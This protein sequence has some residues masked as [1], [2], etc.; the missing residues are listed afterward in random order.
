VELLPYAIQTVADYES[1]PDLVHKRMRW[2]VVMRH[3]RPWG[4]FGLLLTQALPWS[5]AAIAVRPSLG[6]AL[7]YLGSYLG[8]R[9]AMSWV[10]GIHGLKQPVL[11]KKL[12]LIPVW[13]AMAFCIWLISF[14]RNTVRWRGGQYYIRDG[15][16]V[17]ATANPAKE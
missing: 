6:T 12:W 8:L 3:M 5:L 4:H 16:L 11:W 13:D 1:M 15:M 9:I 2:V 17:P 10:I 7:G 14:G